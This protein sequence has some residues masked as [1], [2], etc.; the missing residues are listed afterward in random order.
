M[1]TP[2]DAVAAADTE[3]RAPRVTSARL[4]STPLIV[5][6]AGTEVETARVRRSGR[7]T[8]VRLVDTPALSVTVAVMRCSVSSPWSAKTWLKSLP[9]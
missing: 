4:R 8:K 5:V 2:S 6:V 7:A 3:T 1:D 9:L